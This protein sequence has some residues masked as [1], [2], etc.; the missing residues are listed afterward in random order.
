MSE[1]S[2]IK[3][4]W[5]DPALDF[6]VGRVR[7]N[8]ACLES[9]PERTV[10]DEW[11]CVENGGWVGGHWAGLIW[12]AFAYSQD[13]N[14]EMAARSWAARLL[15]RQFDT[16][17]H[18]LGF[19]FELS[20]ILG[21]KMTGDDSFIAPAMQAAES[22]SQ[23]FNPRGRY[24]QA[25]KPLDA[26]PEYRGRA[27]VD[28]M[29]NLDLLFW[30]SQQAV[31]PQF[32]QMAEAHARTVMKYQIRADYTTSHVI[33]FDPE[34]GEFIKQDTH[35]GLSAN[36]CWSR[37]QAWAVYGFG[38][39]Y[40]ET[41]DP[42][43][44]E[45][46]RNLAEY[47]LENL[48]ADLVPYWDYY[49]PEIPND[50]RDSSAASILASGLLNLAALENNPDKAIYWCNQAKATLKSLWENYTSIGTDIPSVLIHGTRSKPHGMM[51]H[52]LI[53]GDYYFLE[54]LLKLKGL[55]VWGDNGSSGN[56]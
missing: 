18:D 36:S 54:A 12:L 43:F 56:I 33:D 2:K 51:D 9:F 32:S 38:D 26:S 52:G 55:S 29:M 15:P 19:L 14:L 8:L 20:H 3:E 30:A 53:Y 50:V 47:A 10:S 6:I 4:K 41:G 28:T 5:I 7:E 49:S 11:I 40:R 23:R 21:H 42:I 34:S 13:P 22:L 1:V 45:T 48:P 17:T 27:I 24:F 44:L 31:D 46:A 25:W 16:T 37:G 35:Q 39:C